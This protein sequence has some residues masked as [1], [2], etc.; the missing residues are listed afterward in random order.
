MLKKK[1][2]N[3]K[4][5]KVFYGGDERLQSTPLYIFVHPIVFINREEIYDK[6]L[7]IIRDISTA[8]TKAN[9]ELTEI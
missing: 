1:F 5:P 9:T 3:K 8:P 2:T 7:Y 6:K 4:H